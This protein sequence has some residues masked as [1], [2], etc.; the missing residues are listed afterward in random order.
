MVDSSNEQK[1]IEDWAYLPNKT[2][3]LLVADAMHG[4]SLRG[5]EL[6]R[7][8]EGKYRRKNQPLSHIRSTR[9][10]LVNDCDLSLG[11]VSSTIFEN[12]CNL[13]HSERKRTL[14]GILPR[15]PRY[16][17]TMQAK[18]P[19]Y[20]CNT[21]KLK[22][23]HMKNLTKTDHASMPLGIFASK[24]G[25]GIAMP[26]YFA[27]SPSKSSLTR[28]NLCYSKVVHDNN[29]NLTET[30][31]S[32]FTSHFSLPKSAFTL[33][34]VLITLAIIGVVAALT[35]PTVIK[36]YQKQVTVT[37]LKKAYSVLGQIAQKS[38]A[39]NDV[40]NFTEGTVATQK[41]VKE[42]FDTY[43]LPYFNG[44]NVDTSP[45]G[46]WQGSNIAYKYKNGRTYNV[47]I[48]TNY[49]AGR[50]FFST[51][52]GVTYFILLTK[53]GEHWTPMFNPKQEVVV[54][55]NGIK[56]PNVFGKDLFRFWIDFKDG[57]VRTDLYSNT[58]AE[59]N[60]NCNSSGT[61]CAAKI[62]QDGW[63]I[64]YPW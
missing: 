17:P 46:P 47:A 58:T 64:T 43:W 18:N 9:Y 48:Y 30:V 35:L 21:S 34:E 1:S 22:G 50:I 54:D 25:V 31:F 11:E 2:A 42:F 12:S 23:I 8:V 56:P 14:K 28:E 7:G 39:D 63:K 57:I 19:A 60:S 51:P 49:S 44:A 62:M 53:W 36:N 59:I 52:D 32:R 26:T 38:L 3:N 55:V 33:A 20:Y 15:T 37:K 13:R 45:S 16:S 10:T 4:F 29:F 41:S 27:V 6:E 24:Y 40:V 61:A 5:R